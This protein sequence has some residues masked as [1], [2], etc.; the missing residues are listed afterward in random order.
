MI[1]ERYICPSTCNVKLSIRR[2]EI[3]ITRILGRFERVVKIPR[4]E[5]SGAVRTT[6]ET[7]TTF[8]KNRQ[9]DEKKRL[10]ESQVVERE[11]EEEEEEK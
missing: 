4:N 9:R 11:W 2:G 3:G 1:C 7:V 10:I 6:I 8:K 5:G